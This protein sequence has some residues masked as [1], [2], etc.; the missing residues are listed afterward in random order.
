MLSDGDR[1][2]QPLKI[3][4]AGIH[5]AVRGNV[6]VFPH[7]ERDLDEVAMLFPAVRYVAVDDKAA[8]LARIRLHWGERVATVHVLQG[9]YADDPYEGPAPDATIAGIGG[10]VELVGTREALRVFLEGASIR[11]GSH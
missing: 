7:K 8:I 9:K 3:S 5:E 4:R 11:G 6:L 1:T 10:L 2:Y